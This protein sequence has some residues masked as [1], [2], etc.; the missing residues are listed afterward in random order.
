MAPS[1]GQKKTYASLLTQANKYLTGFL[2]LD[3][4]LKKAGVKY[5][6]L[7]VYTDTLSEEGH[8]ALDVR[9]IQK[10]R[11]TAL[12]PA[13][14]KDY[15][16]EVRFHETWSKLA[17]FSLLE[18]E[19]VVMLDSDAFVLKNMD[20]LMDLELDPPSM[21][22]RGDRVF[23]AAHACVCNPMKKPHYPKDWFVC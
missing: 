4:S 10:R 18:Y 9:G 6:L 7:A 16:Q 11:V 2:T 13:K 8:K 23:A 15:S 5:P 21:E 3:Y 14:S 19:R 1:D 20:E 22:G 12:K 17:A